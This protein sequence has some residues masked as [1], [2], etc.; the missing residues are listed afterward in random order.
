VQADVSKGGVVCDRLRDCS[1]GLAGSSMAV[2]AVRK[3]RIQPDFG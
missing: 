2:L 3:R 1:A